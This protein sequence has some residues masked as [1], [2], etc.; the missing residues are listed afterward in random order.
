MTPCR[1][2]CGFARCFLDRLQQI[3]NRKRSGYVFQTSRF[4]LHSISYLEV[5]PMKQRGTD[6]CR[7]IL[8]M[9]TYLQMRGNAELY[10]ENCRRI[11]EYN[12]IRIVVQTTE[13][14]LEIWGHALQADSRSADCLVIIGE[15]E[16]IR[17]SHKGKRKEL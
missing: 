4:F 15:I 11:L 3:G 12:D 16:S 2:L 10:L 1:P 7:R 9:Q 14:Q 17:F 13:L 6:L 5:I 8:S